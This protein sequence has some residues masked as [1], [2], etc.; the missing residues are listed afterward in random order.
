MTGNVCM[1]EILFFKTVLIDAKST[2]K[3][4]Y[5]YDSFKH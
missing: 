2:G 4:Y 1:A 5:K 3:H